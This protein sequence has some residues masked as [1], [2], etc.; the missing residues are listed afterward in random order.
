L[1]HLAHILIICLAINHSFAQEEVALT[2]DPIGGVYE[3]STTVT[4]YAGEGATIYYTTDGTRPHSGSKRYKGP[5]TVDAVLLIRA[6]A[7]KSGKRSDVITNTY[8]C[9]RKY[10]LPVV[11]IATDTSNLWSYETGIYVKGCCAD[12][13]EPYMGAN[14]W[15]SWEKHANIEMYD[16]NGDL[17]FNQGAGI[18]IFGGFSRWLPMKSLAVIARSKYGDNRF[19]YPIFP[20]REHDKYKS[21]I[22]RNSGGDFKRTHFRD[23]FMTQLAKPTGLAIQ[24]YQPAVV[25]INGKYWGIQNIREKINEHYLAQNYDV[26][27]DNVDILRQNGVKRHGYSTNYKKLLAWLR[28]HDLS[29]D[30]NV[31]ELRTFMDVDDFIRYNIAEVYSDNRDAGGNI[32]YWRERNDSAKWRW[33][34]YDIDQGLG[35]NA[36]SGYKR[37]TLQKFTSVNNESWPDPPWS[38]FIIR[39]LLENKKLEQQY[40]N[41]FADHLNVY[42]HP[43]RANALMD[44]MMN[45]IDYEI[46]YHQKRWSSSKKNWKHHVSIMRKF[47]DLR[48][49]YCRKHLMHKF[50]LKDTVNIMIVHPGKD[51]CDIKFNSLELKEDFKG[52][53]FEGIPVQ[54]DIDVK[55]DY[56]FV[57]WKDA[58]D[59]DSKRTIVPKGDMVLEPIIKPRSRSK[60]TG[61]IIF[62][63]IAFYQPE[64]DTTG[65]WIELFNRASEEIDLS[66]WKFTDRTFKKGWELPENTKIDGGGYLV[67]TQDLANFRSTFSADSV[68]ALGDFEFGLSRN[69]EL[70]KLYDNKGKIV[71]SLS[72]SNPFDAD[73][74][75]SFTISLIHPD[76]TA[77]PTAWKAETANPSYMSDGYKDHLKTEAD[78]RY[79]TKI[80]YIGGGSFF[81]ILVAGVLF[82]RYSK[83]KRSQR[84][85]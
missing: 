72:Y 80:F 23:A 28:S 61:D 48:P 39:K 77:S 34:Y 85:S 76:S 5:I 73:Q 29:D 18:S 64:G 42:Y 45:L 84:Q 4:L 33:V 41:T 11:S 69:G 83:K 74:D 57:G 68:I 25:F 70:L 60:Y 81:F 49:G 27:K 54:I 52:V 21:F 1:K 12:T 16:A 10:D 8:V 7:Y 71:D 30:K 32:R 14:Y 67:L 43:E 36:P 78:K 24:E 17:C 63:E 53:Y 82:I 9:D 47:V 15:K 40:I 75:S 22:L 2:F 44:S 51:V 3:K 50:N 56:K 59:K 79:W 46:G 19:R 55:H 6:V 62:N 66:G 31:D 35:N 20:N 13:I 58:Q 37:N 38:T 26:D 65:D